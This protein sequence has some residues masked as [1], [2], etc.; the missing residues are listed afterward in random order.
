MR[1]LKKPSDD[2]T[3]GR[4]GAN[5]LLEAAYAA[6][7]RRAYRS[8]VTSF[9]K[10]GGSIPSSPEQI[11]AFVAFRANNC[12]VA[13]IKRQL[14][15]LSSLHSTL[16]HT[17]NP[18]KSRLVVSTVRGLARLHGKPQRAVEPLLIEHLREI[19][20]SLPG[21][22]IGKRDAALLTIGFAGGLRRSELVG[23]NVED[24]EFVPAGV[25][26][27]IKRSKTDQAGC[28]RL[29]AIQFGRTRYCPIRFLEAWL[30]EMGA[31]KGAAF[32][33]C[34]KGGRIS[35]R[36]L[37]NEAV[38]KIVKRHVA[39]I[40]L[41]PD[42]Y[43]GHSLRAGFVTSAI[44]AGAPEHAVRRQTGHASSATMERY[45]RLANLFEDNP[46]GLLF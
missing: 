25:R 44:M 38:A 1:D 15:S 41:K 16:G 37:S 3:P 33:S 6:N 7:T 23:T 8:D 34:L 10:W 39:R 45:I 27:T 26:M 32:K 11:A 28:G 31:Q 2:N 20:D 29:V 46:T 22:T 43:S 12:T 36:R 19:L 18:V 14:A 13:T 30:A 24:I 9:L 17:P 5:D 35:R 42:E 4:I 40:G 21:S